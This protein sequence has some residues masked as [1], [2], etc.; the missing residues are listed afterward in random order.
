MSKLSPKERALFEVARKGWGPST[1]AANASR[2]GIEARVR[3][4]PD[5]GCAGPGP[6][7]VARSAHAARSLLR[8]PW[9]FVSCVVAVGLFTAAAG[10]TVFVSSR[11]EA[12]PLVPSSAVPVAPTVAPEMAPVRESGT[13][14]IAALPDAPTEPKKTS[15]RTTKAPPAGASAPKAEGIG[16]ELEL[17]RAAQKAL[18]EGSPS[19]A[20]VALDAHGERF[21]RGALREERMTLQVLSLCALGDLPNARR[22]RGE[23]EKLAPASSHLQR[24]DCAAP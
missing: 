12:T 11:P 2:A 14:S 1:S 21:P 8:G 7:D 17:V 18:R 3:N 15:T 10:R 23:L 6:E 22:I 5:A 24:L 16:E 9:A 4:D 19:D 13:V 20:L